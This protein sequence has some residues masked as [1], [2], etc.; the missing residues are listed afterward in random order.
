MKRP[1]AVPWK[2]R[3]PAVVNVP[4]FQGDTCSTRQASFCATGSQAS[5]RPKG[6]DFG[7][8]VFARIAVFQ[9]TPECGCPGR[10]ESGFQS[11]SSTWLIGTF[12]AGKYASPVPGLKDIEC[13]LW[14]PKGP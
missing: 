5:S 2:T 1:S 8:C 9:P 12:C 10:L 13:Q 6:A 3:L 14:A 11:L 7:G 4:P